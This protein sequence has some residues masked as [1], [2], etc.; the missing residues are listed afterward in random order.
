[1]GWWLRMRKE[2]RGEE[3]QWMDR[4]ERAG[5]LNQGKGK[6]RGILL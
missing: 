5:K 2:R 6:E 3:S 4:Q 1:M